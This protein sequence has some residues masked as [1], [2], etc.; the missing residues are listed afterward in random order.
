[1]NDLKMVSWMCNV[2]RKDS[3]SAKELITRLKLNSMRV[4][5]KDRRL[6]WFGHLEI[7]KE[8]ALSSEYR[9]LKFGG[10]FPRG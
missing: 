9:T 6:Q 5:L 8:N 1:M 2:R 3:I 4:Y 7:M 10:N